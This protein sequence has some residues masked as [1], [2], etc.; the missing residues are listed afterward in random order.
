MFYLVSRSQI[1]RIKDRS[2]VFIRAKEY[3]IKSLHNGNLLP[4]WCKI[5]EKSVFWHTKQAFVKRTLQEILANN[6]RSS[7]DSIDTFNASAIVE[8]IQTDLYGQTVAKTTKNDTAADVHH[9]RTFP[10]M[11]ADDKYKG[12]FQDFLSFSERVFSI[13]L[14]LSSGKATRENLK[15]LFGSD[16]LKRVETDF[17]NIG[18]LI[19]TDSAGYSFVR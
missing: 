18:T 7:F 2:G 17:S 4:L 10:T 8:I 15:N 14:A 6:M 9:I 19:Q 16:A 13:K 5:Q 12:E 11:P 1:E 3:A